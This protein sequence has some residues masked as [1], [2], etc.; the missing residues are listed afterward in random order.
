VERF[1]VAESI[2]LLAEYVEVET[3]KGAEPLDRRPVLREAL[4]Q[5]ERQRLRC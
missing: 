2:A 3:G 1:A 4:A 5:A